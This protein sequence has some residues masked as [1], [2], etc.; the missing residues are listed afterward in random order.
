MI[1]ARMATQRIALQAWTGMDEERKKCTVVGTGKVVVGSAGPR[2]D[3]AT[4]G[5]EQRRAKLCGG[6]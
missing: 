2:F 4:W 3:S 6:G 1:Y 5:P